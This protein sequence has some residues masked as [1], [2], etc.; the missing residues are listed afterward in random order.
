MDLNHVI[1]SGPDQLITGEDSLKYLEE[2]VHDFTHPVIVTGSRS[3]AAFK[4]R[5][6]EKQDWPIYQYDGSASLED[7]ERLTGQIKQTDAVLAIGGGKLIDTAK[8]VA[9]RRKAR[10]IA[11]PTTLGTCA[12]YSTHSILYTP[13][14]VFK[15]RE[16]HKNAAYLLLI[17]YQL[18]LDSPR[19][20]FLGGIGDTLAKWYESESI[21]RHEDYLEPVVEL[22]PKLAAKETRENLFKFAEEAVKDFEN[23]KLSRAFK[24]IV[25]TIIVISGTVGG[26]GTRFGR[27]SGAHAIHNAMS[28]I[29][30]T[31][32]IPHGVKVAYGVLVLL[33]T[34][35]ESATAKKLLPFYRALG[36]L[37]SLKQFQIKDTDGA[38]RIIA[39]ISS[40]SDS[41]YHYAI[42]EITAEDVIDG[43][44]ELERY[45]HEFVLRR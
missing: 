34:E 6:G 14:H 11:I 37:T 16:Y 36:L 22:G 25:D 19:F 29:P 17:D 33:I 42:P 38:K 28:E 8:G 12:P 20:L 18:L 1:R 32:Q 41:K 7:I 39:E 23:K 44:D 3:Y 26:F 27:S 15:T 4:R 43:I 40:A 45:N 30:E 13:D 10:L 2:V 9:A 31:H 24:N 21:T 35:K 5:Y